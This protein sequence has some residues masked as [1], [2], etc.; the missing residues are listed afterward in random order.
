MAR[1][2]YVPV[3][4]SAAEMGSEAPGYKAAYIARYGEAKWAKR[5]AE[6]DA[7][8]RAIGAAIDQLGLDF[9]RVKLYQ[10]SL[11]VCGREAELARDLAAQGS[12]NHQLLEDLMRRG[13]TLVGAE[14]PKLLLDEYKLLQSSARTKAQAAALLEA[15]DR[16]IAERIEATLGDDEDGLLFIGALHHVAKFLPARIKVEYLS[17]RGKNGRSTSAKGD[18]DVH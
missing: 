3:V 10:D 13:A 8:W 4:H 12:R 11:P 15:R 7:V 18:A 6:F 14:S 5:N 1:L 16:F 17:P 2:I 9:R